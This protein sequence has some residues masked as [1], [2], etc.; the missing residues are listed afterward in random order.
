MS[1]ALVASVM[2]LTIETF[3]GVVIDEV[4]EGVESVNIVEV[5]GMEI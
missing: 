2:D 3:C 5:N 1:D 4:I